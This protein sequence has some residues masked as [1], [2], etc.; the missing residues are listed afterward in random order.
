MF[1][2]LRFSDKALYLRSGPL[3]VINGLAGLNVSCD[4]S[5]YLPAMDFL[6]SPYGQG[7]SDQDA[8]GSQMMTAPGHEPPAQSALTRAPPSTGDP[9]PSNA[10]RR[11]RLLC[12]PK[13]LQNQC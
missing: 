3:K 12:A 4:G 10:E 2:I 11:S 5:H 9:T 1:R 8:P 6:H 13:A 7:F